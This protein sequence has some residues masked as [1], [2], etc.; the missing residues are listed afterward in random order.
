[1]ECQDDVCPVCLSEVVDSESCGLYC[2]HNIHIECIKGLRLLTCP[3][4]RKELRGKN[5]SETTIKVIKNNMK[6]D[7][8]EEERDRIRRTETLIRELSEDSMRDNAHV[9]INTDLRLAVIKIMSH[10]DVK[11]F[12]TILDDLDWNP[13]TCLPIIGTFLRS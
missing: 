1:M 10:P 2:N 13:M 5:L 4:C 8:K 3:I 6:I 9:G 7:Q 12:F 11:Y